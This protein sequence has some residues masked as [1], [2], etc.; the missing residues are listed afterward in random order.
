MSIYLLA[1]LVISQAEQ[2]ADAPVDATA[3]LRR[4]RDEFVELTPGTEPYAAE[5]T[6]GSDTASPQERPA[7]AVRFEYPFSIA[8]YEVTQE[9]YQAV[10]GT[11]PSRWQ[12]PRNSV[13]RVSYDDAVAFCHRATELLRE[14][15]LIRGDEEVRLP[16]E[17]EW[18]YAVRAGSTTRYSFGDDPAQLG[19][20]AWYTGN[21]AGNDP[22]V[23]AKRPNAWKLYDLHGYLWEWTADAWHDD[24]SGAPDEGSPRQAKE[25][26]ADS[27]RRVL[28]GG[29]WKDPAEL[30]TSTY[31]RAA[32]A[33][34]RDDAVGFR[35]VLA[36]ER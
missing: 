26:G 29:S 19:E 18:E 9:L 22:P 27:P 14:Q 4:F 21:A 34:L 15:E 24:Y 16:S 6:M 3:I 31:R 11:N 30:L 35:C 23:G 32:P 13:E 5:F 25:G 2:R 12:G 33:E 17:A 8:R 7:H 1:A 28:R 10:T 20:F 36:G